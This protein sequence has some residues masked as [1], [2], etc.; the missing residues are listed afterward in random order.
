LDEVMHIPLDYFSYAKA[1]TLHQSLDELLVAA[2][3]RA[4]E[5]RAMRRVM[6]TTC[7]DFPT[8]LSDL[9]AFVVKPVL[10]GLAF[11]VSISRLSFVLADLMIFRK[12]FCA[13]DPP[14]IWWCATGPL[15]FLPIHAAGIYNDSAAGYNISDYVV[16]SYT[17]TLNALLN[18]AAYHERHSNF[19]G[20]L[21][22]SQPNTPGQSALPNTTVELAE[23]QKQTHDFRVHVLEG[24]VAL[25][26]SVVEGMKTHSW[27]HL[28]CHAVQDVVEPTRSAFCLHDGHLE[29]STII[30]KSFP[31]ADFAFLSACQT[32]TG[33]EKLPEEAVHL[34]AGLML[35]GYSGVI[36]TMWSIMDKD[37]PVIAGQVYAELFSGV[38][39]DSTKAALALHHAVKR[40][41][42]QGGD[43]AFW[44]WVPFIHVG[45]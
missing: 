24:P 15:A 6:T 41:R 5:T 11:T 19:R 2:G 45:I 20:L 42:Q 23:I 22:V 21:S 25:V 30:T 10:D 34:A 39:P 32:A 9:W 1:L 3:V 12:S 13:E 26:E 36:A 40:L 17:P 33:A 27:L 37:A 44:S 16:S 7:V 35:A 29:L 31:D 28:A 38:H 18:A 8:I 43:T 14:R 4:R